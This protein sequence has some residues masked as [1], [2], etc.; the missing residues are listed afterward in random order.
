MRDIPKATKLLFSSPPFVFITVGG[1]LEEFAITV[2]AMFM[3]KVIEV[4]FYQMPERSALIY[5]LTVVPSALVGNLLGESCLELVINHK[6]PAGS[7]LNERSLPHERSRQESWKDPG[8]NLAKL[9]RDLG[10]T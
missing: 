6:R 5:G 4:Q 8:G 9:V 3:P 10:A 1:C 2:S 7:L